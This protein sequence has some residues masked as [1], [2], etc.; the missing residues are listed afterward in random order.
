MTQKTLVEDVKKDFE[1]MGEQTAAILKVFEM[2]ETGQVVPDAALLKVLTSRKRE[3]AKVFTGAFD[4]AIEY[5]KGKI[6][7]GA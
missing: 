1:K 7:A 5:V 3:A 6:N 4:T 2:I